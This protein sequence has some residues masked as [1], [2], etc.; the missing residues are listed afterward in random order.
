MTFAGTKQ[1]LEINFWIATAIQI[2]T[3]SETA[4]E[5]QGANRKL[6]WWVNKIPRQ[7]LNR[8][9]V[10]WEDDHKIVAHILIGFWTALN[11]LLSLFAM[12]PEKF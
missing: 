6:P 8:Q 9:R 11:A 3:N 4:T 7:R 1:T 10:E 12:Y 5:L 2:V